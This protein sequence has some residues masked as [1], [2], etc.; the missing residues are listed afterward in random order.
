VDGSV[1][2]YHWYRFI[3]Q[4]ALQNAGLSVPEK[5]KLQALVEKIHRAWTPDK[6]YMAPPR[7]GRLASVDSAILVKPPKGLEVGYVPVAIRQ[8]PAK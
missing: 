6:S 8:D 1:V 2:T 7:F 4:P 3:D 5:N